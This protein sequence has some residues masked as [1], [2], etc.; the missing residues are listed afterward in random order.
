MKVIA[1]TGWGQDADRERSRTA[2]CDGHLVKP[3]GLA[4][5]QRLLAELRPVI[6]SA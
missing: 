2:G 5:L 4:D 1:V 6:A 3:V